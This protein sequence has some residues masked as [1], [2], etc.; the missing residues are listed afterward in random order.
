MMN[1]SEEVPEE[2]KHIADELTRLAAVFINQ[3]GC[4]P[5]NV[6][7]AFITVGMAVATTCMQREWAISHLREL[8][9]T[10]G[11]PH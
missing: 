9:T 10:F 11:E 7:R 8:L 2:A 3:S 6:A 1:L 4:D 5:G